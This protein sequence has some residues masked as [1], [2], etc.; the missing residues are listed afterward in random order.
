MIGPGVFS[1][2]PQP[3]ILSGLRLM[4]Y[5]SADRGCGFFVYLRLFT[6]LLLW[7]SPWLRAA[8]T[9]APVGWE[10]IPAED[11]AATECKSYPGSSAEL[12]FV[13]QEL[14]CVW[15]EQLTRYY[16]RAK[17]YSPKGADEAGVLSVEYSSTE[18]S[19]NPVARLTKPDGR[20]TE[21]TEK[22]FT[23]SLSWQIGLAKMKRLT[24]AVP[25]LG[26]GDIL[27]MKWTET[28]DA[29]LG[30]YS[31]WY[32]QN[33]LPVRRFV[34][35]L[36]RSRHDCQLHAFN[37][38][39]AQDLPKDP[40]GGTGLEI[41][42]IPPFVSEPFLPPLRDIRGWF[43]LLYP[44]SYRHEES[45]GEIWQELSKKREEQHRWQIKPNGAV[46][47]KSAE[48]LR[49]ASTDEEKLRRLYEFCQQQIAN[50]DYVDTAEMRK[51][52]KKMKELDVVPQTPAQT[53][54]RKSGYSK[55]I[56]ELFASLAQAAG[57]EVRL[58][59]GASRLTTLNV[60]HPNGW[61]FLRDELEAIRVNGGWRFY[62]PGD[63]YVPAGMLDSANESA[64]SIICDP[65]K[66]IFE[67]NPVSPASKSQ[68]I[69]K[70]RFVLD[71]AGN[72]V[73]N[74]E[75]SMGG[76]AGISRK[77]FYREE[78]N[79]AIDADYR[80][81]ITK[82]LPAAEI[83]DLSWENLR[84]NTLPLIVRYRLKVPAYADEAGS[85]RFLPV[86][87]FEH[88]EAPIFSAESRRHPVFFNYAWSEHDDIEI[89]LP[90]ELA[91]DTGS[92]P[93]DIGDTT[94][95]LAATYQI[96]YSAKERKLVY[97]RDF[98][99][100]RDGTIVFQAETYPALKSLFDDIDRSDEHVL[101]LRRE[102]ATASP[103]GEVWV[104]PMRLA[105]P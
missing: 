68:V 66:I 94:S 53:L 61:I 24:L 67:N 101:V 13:R 54:S 74:V 75:I 50:M 104:Q 15:D 86:N 14:D 105:R 5:R 100:G 84:G 36:K 23:E 95:I 103:A 90:P 83:T 25:D 91:L 33:T 32:T 43:M 35:S 1:L 52:A 99:L 72:L 45:P 19:G 82:R 58:A 55:Q 41:H 9:Q 21:F 80:A 42:D 18:K 85:K 88:G 10:P 69:R 64:T 98:A 92:T 65:E 38:P 62:A 40:K 28:V 56:N 51:A 97:N 12:L 7:A 26:P 31:W 37:Q 78:L 87:V 96:G 70:G 79:E 22:A 59:L 63:Y 3:G 6:G 102:S 48:L 17:I 76:H 49:G 2:V 27:E 77:S 34:F 89:T 16:Q 44:E 20:Q 47:A 71:A 93:A 11:L 30:T 29:S 60:R 73:G 81:I 46:K 8:G 57:F 39:A 4:P